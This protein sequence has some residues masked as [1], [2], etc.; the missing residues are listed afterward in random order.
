M[1]L[2]TRRGERMARIIGPC[3]ITA[4]LAR[5][6]GW[7][8]AEVEAAAVDLRLLALRTADDDFVYPAF[9]VHDGAIVPGLAEVLQALSIGV[10][11]PWT[12]AL[13]LRGP[14]SAEQASPRSSIELLIAGE[15][16]R[17]LRNARH[18]A[19]AWGGP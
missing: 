14:S 7:S 19:E 18:A 1:S 4:S 10:E 13:W 16:E 12:W 6:L 17:V 3:Y 11:D 2:H 8:P 5:E 15:L 9:Q